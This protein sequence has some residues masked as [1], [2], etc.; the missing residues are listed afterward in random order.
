MKDASEFANIYGHCFLMVDKPKTLVGTRGEELEKDIRPYISLITAENITDWHYTRLPNGKYI[1]DKLIVR[2]DVTKDGTLYK[3]WYLDQVDTVYLEEKGEAKLIDS[4][5]NPLG[6]IPAVILYSQRSP[7]RG[8][9]L[10]LLQDIA[11]LQQAIYNE[12]SEIE[13]LIRLSNHPSLVK[14]PGVEASA[15]A[16]S[17]VLMPEETP[18]E[19]KPYQ[20]Q[21]SGANL[22]S[23]RESIK[24]KVEAIN[25]ISHLGAV[26]TLR[27]Q[28]SSGVALRTEFNLLN[29]RLTSQAELLQLAEEQIWDLIALW[30][31]KVFDGEINYSESYDIRDYSADMDFYLKTQTANVPSKAFKK[32][33]D[34]KI[35]QTVIDDEEIL[36]EINNEIDTQPDEPLGQFSPEPAEEPEVIEEE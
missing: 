29:S 32:E 33:L 22:D 21:P 2:E 3:V 30:Q 5:P 16:G 34:R 14:T 6:R 24:D 9:G 36:N 20:L 26:R 8:I 31:G 28:P 7:K 19:L 27:Q 25:R 12:L 4:Q 15:G 35:V 17:I 11:E 13:Q 10:S 18:P 23:V 1:L